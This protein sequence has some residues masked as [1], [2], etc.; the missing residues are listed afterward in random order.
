MHIGIAYQDTEHKTA[1]E[2]DD[3]Y[4]PHF[5]PDDLGNVAIARSVVLSLRIDAEY[6]RK[7]FGVDAGKCAVWPEFFEDFCATISPSRAAELD[8]L[9]MQQHLH[10]VSIA[11][12]FI[13]M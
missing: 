8:E 1:E 4:F 11:T 2:L 6:L 12:S 3:A 7:I 5:R 9:R 10:S 13:F